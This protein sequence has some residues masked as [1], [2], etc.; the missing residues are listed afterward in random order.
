M[1]EAT[2]ELPYAS[3]FTADFAAVN[4]VANINEED[5][6]AL[7]RVLEMLQAKI[8]ARLSLNMVNVRDPK[9]TSDEQIL[10]N[11]QLAADLGEIKILVQAAID[12]LK[13]G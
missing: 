2:E 7:K 5:I 9:F 13:E 3:P 10:M 1:D 8:D 6:P 11:Q 12:D 4:R